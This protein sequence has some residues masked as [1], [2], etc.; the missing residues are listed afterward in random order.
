MN[1]AGREWGGLEED[2][3]M[4]QYRAGM[5]DKIAVSLMEVAI[6]VVI[7]YGE[8]RCHGRNHCNPSNV[9]LMRLMMQSVADQGSSHPDLNT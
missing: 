3:A 7:R 4:V 6:F 2:E 8:E 5:A 1:V 9:T